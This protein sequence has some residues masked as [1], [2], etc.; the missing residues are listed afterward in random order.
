MKA[1]NRII[2]NTLAQ[3]IRT[4]INMVLSLYSSRLVLNILGVEDF[5]VYSLVAGVISMLSFFTN[6]LVGSTQRFLSV[7]QGKG[8]MYKL[9]EVFNNSLILHL[10]LGT[11]V[12]LILWGI[13]PLLFNGFLNIPEGRVDTAQVLC[14]LVVIMVFISFIASP[15]RALLISHENIVYI[16]IIDVLD[17]ILKV[18]LVTLLP[19]ISYDKLLTYGV[20]MLGIQLFNL[21]AFMIYSHAKYEECCV[22]R[23]KIFSLA[24]VKNL[25]SFTGWILYSSVCIT[26]RTQGLSIVLNRIYGAV[27]NAAYGIGAQISGM[28]AFVS[29]SFDNAVAPQLMAAEGGGNRQNMLALATIQSKISFLLLSMIGIPVM[30]QM[31]FILKIWLGNVPEHTMLFGCMFLSMQIIDMLSLGLAN[32]K[33]AIGSIG[34]YTLVTS[35][36]KLLAL[37]LS[38]AVLKL[39][40]PLISVA[41]I[42]VFVEAIC[43]LLRIYLFRKESWFKAAEYINDV[44]IRNIPPVI[45]SAVVCFLCNMVIDSG[46]GCF[47]FSFALSIPSFL[48]IAYFIS[49]N[50]QEKVFVKKI[51]NKVLR[52]RHDEVKA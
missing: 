1:S 24:Y 34:S 14:R 9:K 44:I 36:P 39:D 20:I 27:I 41:V 28:I 50:K 8:D 37:P 32:A 13:T 33:K 42:L 26:A 38:W 21:F 4:I 45:V 10:G 31:Q 22:P 11:C 47:F 19:S 2:V 6:S 7:S 12:A 49:L 40:M 43:M 18:V 16:S 35:T 29:T 46:V 30:F 17:G 52:R 3:Y 15:Y 25:L 51:V 23:L 5:G 48:V